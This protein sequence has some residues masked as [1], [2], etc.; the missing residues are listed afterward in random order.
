MAIQRLLLLL[1]V[2]HNMAREIIMA[3]LLLS[4]SATSSTAWI[5]ADPNSERETVTLRYTYNYTHAGSDSRCLLGIHK[6]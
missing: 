4:L 5:I 1:V 3:N 6:S 2:C